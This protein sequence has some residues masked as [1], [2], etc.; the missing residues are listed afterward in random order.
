MRLD[1][2]THRT[3]LFQI[4]QEIYSDTTISPF[5][6]FKGGTAALM[7][8]GLDRFSLD[9]DF[10][11]LDETKEDQ[12]FEGVITILKRIGT[13]RESRKKHFN[14]FCLLSYESKAHNIKVEVNRRQFGSRYEIKSYLGVSMLVMVP[15]DMFAHKLMAMHERIGKT[16]RDI[17]DVWFFLKQRFP[18]NKAIV[19]QRSGMAFAELIE[20]CIHQLEAMSNRHILDGVGELLTSSQKDW[21]RAKLRQDTIALLR[22]RLESDR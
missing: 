14:L 4:L 8:Y 5:V 12:V 13:L 18:I 21:A 9:L 17:Y 11:L 2:S 22:L 6:G 15:E 3:I 16:S 19:E 20:I 10:D 7:F 1:V